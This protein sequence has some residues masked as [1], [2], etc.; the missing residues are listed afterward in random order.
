MSEPMQGRRL[1]DNNNGPFKLGQFKPG[2]YQKF[3]DEDG[4]VNWF[5]MAPQ[6]DVG[7]L[8]AHTIT[9]HED[10]TITVA[11]SILIYPAADSPGWHGYLEHGVWREC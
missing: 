6:G 5:C 9:E 3:V 10:G 4:E 8:G 11:P 7:N 1:P 2:D